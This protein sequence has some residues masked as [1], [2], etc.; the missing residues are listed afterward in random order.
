MSAQAPATQAPSVQAA[1]G[2][3]SPPEACPLCGAPLAPDQEWCLSCGAAA[4]TRLA[5][6]PGWKGPI[7]AIAT[8]A[9]LALGVLAAALVKLAGDSGPAPVAVTRTITTAAPPAAATP[10]TALPGAATTPPPA[11]TPTTTTPGAAS[12]P[13]QT[14]STP[15]QTTSSTQTET[16]PAAPPAGGGSGATNTK[17]G[18]GRLRGLAPK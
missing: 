5:A 1:P 9:V 14:T 6:A 12:T 3:Q 8:V 11:S 10:T 15:A 18:K 4:R 16:T 7:V 17:A 13:A 2:V